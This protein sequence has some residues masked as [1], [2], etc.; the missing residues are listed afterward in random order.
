MRFAQKVP[1]ILIYSWHSVGAFFTSLLEVY[2]LCPGRF[3]P[4]DKTHTTVL[5]SLDNNA[6]KGAGYKDLHRDVWR[7]VFL[8]WE[9]S[10]FL[11]RMSHYVC[12]LQDRNHMFIEQGVCEKKVSCV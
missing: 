12:M 5:L 1:D 6:G 11:T 3:G 7:R 4:R 10:I 2:F 9:R 8:Y